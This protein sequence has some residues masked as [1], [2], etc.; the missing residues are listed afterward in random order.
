MYKPE[1]ALKEVDKFLDQLVQF[2]QD[3]GGELQGKKL[4][5]IRDALRGLTVKNDEKQYVSVELDKN[6]YI[7]GYNIMDTII[8][9]K[10]LPEDLDKG[11]YR[12]DKNN[13]P[14]LDKKRRRDLWGD[15]MQEFIDL[16][17]SNI[18]YVVGIPAISAAFALVARWSVNKLTTI[19]IPW[20]EKIVIKV[21]GQFFGGET[22]E[23][24]NQLPI[25]KQMQSLL[26]MNI[27]VAEMELIRLKKE[28][29]NPLYSAEEKLVFK[30]MFNAM[31]NIYKDQISEETKTVLGIFE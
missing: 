28:T 20:V 19:I 22:P 8:E 3:Q 21:I 24:V 30:A 1:V 10:D 26:E 17:N 11:Y 6:G 25:V 4:S 29:V 23:D 31:Y 16:I 18:E 12:L 9:N 2:I 27:A 14:V 5:H 13:K 15:Q 7:K